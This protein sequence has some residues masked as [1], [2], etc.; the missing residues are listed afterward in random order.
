MSECLGALGP[1]L[2]CPEPPPNSVVLA[3]RLTSPQPCSP[4]GVQGPL[5]T[6]VP[7]TTALVLTGNIARVVPH[8]LL[9]FFP[10]YPVME[11]SLEFW[12]VCLPLCL[13]GVEGEPQMARG[14]VGPQHVPFEKVKCSPWQA[15]PDGRPSPPPP[16]GPRLCQEAGSSEASVRGAKGQRR[17]LGGPS[18]PGPCCPLWLPQASCRPDQ[19]LSQLHAAWLRSCLGPARRPSG[20]PGTGMAAADLCL[21]GGSEAWLPCLLALG[22]GVPGLLGNTEQALGVRSGPA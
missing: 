4:W 11:K 1:R 14:L 10:S 19:E 16:T 5:Q 6:P 9:V 15:R 18:S 17:L 8:G 2:P 12:R 22:N 3:A 21:K 20:S 7:L 13:L